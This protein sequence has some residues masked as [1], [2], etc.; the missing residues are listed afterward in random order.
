MI[1]LYLGK[2]YTKI[3]L[4]KKLHWL[5]LDSYFSNQLSEDCHLEIF[6]YKV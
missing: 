3:K 1:K 4:S 5:M 2:S 6:G